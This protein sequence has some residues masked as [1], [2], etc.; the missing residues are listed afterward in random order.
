[1]GRRLLIPDDPE[2]LEE[3]LEYLAYGLPQR[4]IALKLGVHESTVSKWK[5]RKDISNKLASRT[6]QVLLEPAKSLAKSNPGLFLQT[7][8]AT[9]ESHAP[10]KQVSENTGSVEIVIRDLGKTN[11]N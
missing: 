6:L 2:L 4:E 9:R 1:M 10:P 7:H 8:P 3:L 11:K 5:T